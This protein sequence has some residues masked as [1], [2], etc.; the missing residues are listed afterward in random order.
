M[1]ELE[2]KTTNDKALE[3]AIK[4]YC[5]SYYNFDYPNQKQG[6]NVMPHVI[7][8]AQRFYE[9][10][11]SN[12]Q[13]KH[14]PITPAVLEKNYFEHKNKDR[15]LKS[16]YWILR[17]R[18][19]FA[20]AKLNRGLFYFQIVGIPAREGYFCPSYCAHIESVQQLKDAL[21]LCGMGELVDNFND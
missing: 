11:K 5:R 10:G 6:S 4:E 17:F 21:K 3:N 16:Q 13:G 8:T 2:Y 18:G 14:T 9:L 15:L 19:G 7:E 20:K 12:Q 1:E